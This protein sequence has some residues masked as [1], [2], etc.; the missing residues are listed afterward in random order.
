MLSPYIPALVS[1]ARLTD[2]R[3]PVERELLQRLDEAVAR[4]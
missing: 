1:L 3:N 4:G 2:R